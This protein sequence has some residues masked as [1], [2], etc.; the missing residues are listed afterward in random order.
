MSEP[1]EG[2]HVVVGASG[3]TGSA[4][5]RELHATGHR[6]RAINRSGRMIAPPGVEVV[7]A[8]ATDAGQMRRACAGAAV[9]YNCVNPPFARWRELFPA[10]VDGVLAGAAAAGAVLVLADDT[11]MYGRVAEPMTEDTPHRPVSGKGVLRAWLAERVLATHHRGEV[12]VVVG[13]AGELFGP[14]VE[15][16]LGRNLFVPAQ[17]GG[18]ARWFGRL[19]RP[20]TPMFV[21]DFARGLIVLGD[22]AE[23]HGAARHVPHPDPLTGRALVEMIFRAAG[24]TSRVTALPTTAV[25]ALGLVSPLA[26]HGAEMIYQFEMPFVVDGSRFLRAFG[27][28]TTPVEDAVATTLDWYRTTTASRTPARP[29][30][31]RRGRPTSTR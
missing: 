28:K 7:A 23:A 29:V 14:G 3:G 30:G 9:V 11:W 12:R 10:A 1:S 17:R 27:A 18:T 8:D 20:L 16:V 2:L 19:D 15:S 4:I 22:R 31:V 26:R 5:V 13:R 6:V 25:R 24:T 21:D